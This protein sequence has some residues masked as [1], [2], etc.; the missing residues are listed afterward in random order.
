MDRSSSTRGFT[1]IELLVVLGIVSILTAL[2]LPAVQMAREAARRSQCQNSLR[3]IGLAIQSYLTSSSCFPASVTT[4]SYPKGRTFYF[5]LYSAHCR[6]LPYLEQNSLYQSIN[7]QTGTW[8]PDTYGAGSS[9]ALAN[10]N[11]ANATAYR[12]GL[13]FFLCPSD[14]GPMETSGSNYRGN[15]G[16]GPSPAPWAESPDS[17]NGLFPELDAVSPAR[18]TDGLSHT[19]AFSERVR[20]SGPGSG[21]LDPERDVFGREGVVNTG[22][23]LLAECRIAGRSSNLLGFRTSGQYWFWAGRE[24]TLYT[25]TQTPNGKV[26]DCTYGGM[27][28]AIDM[29]TARSHHPGGVN[30]LMGDGSG[31][32]VSETIAQAVWRA[33]GSRDG[34]E[35]V[36]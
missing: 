36:D 22:D 9:G 17:G 32:F 1:L 29:A 28:P 12:T 2:L 7:F 31:R 25:H 35:I 30:V 15:T 10:L 23:Q 20:G 3:Q 24:R 33:L 16:I 8:P 19:V 27:T 13:A 14:G 21:A 11:L 26:P 34:G 4:R 6:L 5:G 18:V